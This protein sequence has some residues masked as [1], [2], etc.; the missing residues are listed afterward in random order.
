M[1]ANVAPINWVLG[2]LGITLGLSL[3]ETLMVIAAGNAVGCAV[4]GRRGAVVPGVIQG[5]LTMGWVGINTWV[6]LDLAITLLAKLGIEGGDGLKYLV[7]GV[8]MALQLGLAVFG[9]YAIRTFEKWTEPATVAVMAVMTVLSLTQVDVR[10]GGDSAESGGETFTAVTQLLT[11]IGVG[12]GVSWVPY[13]AHYSRF[14]APGVPGRRVFW[15]TALGMYVPTVW[16]A[17]LGA[18]LASAGEGGDPS[19][20]VVAAFGVMALPVL[21]LIMHGP[22]ATNILNLYSCALAALSVGVR[23]ARWKVTLLAGVVATGVLLVF[24]QSPSFARSFDHWMVSI[25]VWISPWAGVMMTEFFILRGGRVD[26]ASLYTTDGP[27]WRWRALAALCAGIVAGWCWQYGLVS[28]MQGPLA[29]ALGNT[30]FSWLAGGLV[31]GGL[32]YLLARHER[33]VAARTPTVAGGPR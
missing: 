8:I 29:R 15:A 23:V 22:V 32:H 27:P 1:G 28:V 25:L 9:F 11:A 14:V 17:A 16:L 31:A 30:D 10:W 2:A 6:I 33:R 18:C 20:L 19:Q 12:W 7:A 5:V 4:F 24:M 3:A 26:V 21:L 13:S